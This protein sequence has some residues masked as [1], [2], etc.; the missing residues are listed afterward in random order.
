MSDKLTPL[1]IQNKEFKRRMKGYDAADVDA[2]M[3]Q[4]R[5]TLETLYRDNES[6]EQDNRNL[7]D[8]L[9]DFERLEV[10][11]RDTLT[12]AQKVSDSIRDNAQK[13]AD[14]I[15]AQAEMEGERRLRSL[16]Q[17]KVELIAQIHELKRE[18]VQFETRLKSLIEVHQRLLE[19]FA[20]EEERIDKV[21]ETL[22]FSAP[23][24]RAS[25]E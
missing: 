12:T 25:G 23:T 18:R 11:L 17:R 8:R 14:A 22:S 13:E 4:V 9:S 10:T 3:L 24:E 21:E 6:M 5:E 1:D 2:F 19:A 20:E 16:D 7:R 15:V